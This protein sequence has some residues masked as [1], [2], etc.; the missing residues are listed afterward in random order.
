M[1]IVEF[2]RKLL[3]GPEPIHSFGEYSLTTLAVLAPAILL[4]WLLASALY[5]TLRSNRD[6]LGSFNAMQLG[7]AWAATALGALL[8]LDMVILW[9]LARLVSWSSVTP[10]ATVAILGALVGLLVYLGGRTQL[11]NSR[12]ALFRAQQER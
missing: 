6:D 8:V 4:A 2:Y 12:R 5:S 10:H 1:D 9:I 3:A 7:W 11:K